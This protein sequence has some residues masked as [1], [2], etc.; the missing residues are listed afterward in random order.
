M[1]LHDCHIITA[2]G[3]LCR[4][5]YAPR[6]DRESHLSTVSALCQRARP[7]A[8]V[9]DTSTL[10]EA[11]HL[12]FVVGV[13][14]SFNHAVVLDGRAPVY[15]VCFLSPQS[16]EY[17]LGAGRGTYAVVAPP[18][19]QPPLLP[20][21]PIFEV[22]RI[23]EASLG[24][25][26]C[27]NVHDVELRVDGLAVATILPGSHDYE[28]PA[29][30]EGV[31][32]LSANE[33]GLCL[34]VG[35][36]KP[37]IMLDAQYTVPM[38]G[39]KWIDFRVRWLHLVTGVATVKLRSRVATADEQQVQLREC[40][41]L[42]EVRYLDGEHVCGIC[43]CLSATRVD[44]DSVGAC[45]GDTT[46]SLW[47][48]GS[49]GLAVSCAHNSLRW[50]DGELVFD[51][52]RHACSGESWCH[53]LWH[54]GEIYVDGRRCCHSRRCTC[55]TVWLT[56]DFRALAVYSA[57]DASCIALVSSS[58]DILL[59]HTSIRMRLRCRWPHVAF[60]DDEALISVNDA[61][62]TTCLHIDRG[63]S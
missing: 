27:G 32:M 21:K 33:D 37:L 58:P 44:R 4:A 46:L 54:A 59:Q 34:Q 29:A 28:L 16:G 2:T 25:R 23:S 38:G 8:A 56:G 40:S 55:E 5:I 22:E 36:R 31:R 63:K 61:N 52:G 62:C 26:A 20:P 11:V 43:P 41:D 10:P 45:L 35:P 14:Q 17:K 6:Q 60:R 19:R 24:L 47:V 9:L 49:T 15:S 39:C 53:V 50:H 3:G 42:V 1:L 30:T 18:W 13:Q 48:C 7:E 51:E 57:F 12:T